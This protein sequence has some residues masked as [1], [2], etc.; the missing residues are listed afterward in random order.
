MKSSSCFLK[1]LTLNWLVLF[2][3]VTVAE[4]NDCQF[5][6]ADRALK[7]ASC[8]VGD[9]VDII[10]LTP[11][12]QASDEANLSNLPTFIIRGKESKAVLKAMLISS[13]SPYDGF[14][15]LPSPSAILHFDDASKAVKLKLLQLG[16]ELVDAKDIVYKGADGSEGAGVV[17]STL[18][19]KI[20]LE[21]VAVAQCNGFYE[22]DISNLKRLLG[23][24][25]GQSNR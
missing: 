3:S 4:D 25:E 18:T 20:G 9:G 7:V 1:I 21:F 14:I 24:V 15:K 8:S 5:D 11:V 22:A 17:C 2:S 12:D 13:L 16:W 23:F 19:K 6:L 10:K